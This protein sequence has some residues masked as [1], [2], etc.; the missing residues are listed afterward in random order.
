[1]HTCK[2][3]CMNCFALY[4]FLITKTDLCWGG[5]HVSSMG[6]SSKINQKG[7]L[8]FRGYK[9]FLLLT[10][11]LYLFLEGFTYSFGFYYM[12]HLLTLVYFNVKNIL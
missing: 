3:V 6:K 10:E 12:K 4:W 2:G 8:Y 9:T 11:L 7:S 5:D 1:M